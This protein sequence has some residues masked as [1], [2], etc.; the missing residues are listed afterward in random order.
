[1]IK[2]NKSLYQKLIEIAKSK[3][4][5]YYKDVADICNLN[6]NDPDDRNH[7]L[8]DILD[9]INRYEHEEG[10]PMITAVVVRKTKP[11][12]CGNGFFELAREFGKM[13][14]GQSHEEFF[15]EE[16]KRVYEFWEKE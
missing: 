7:I 11:R 6:L 10:R 15:R 13:E 16:L 9:D 2:I 12:I 5:L 8:R 14:K 4:T 1:M 3:Q